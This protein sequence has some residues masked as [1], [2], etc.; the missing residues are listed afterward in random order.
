MFSIHLMIYESSTGATVCPFIQPTFSDVHA[1]VELGKKFRVLGRRS[2]RLR[3]GVMVSEDRRRSGGRRR[4]RTG[5]S[6]GAGK[7][8]R[9]DGALDRT[10]KMSDRDHTVLLWIPHL[11]SRGS[12]AQEMSSRCSLVILSC[13]HGDEEKTLLPSAKR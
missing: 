1:L 13:T 7:E 6:T 4:R 12:T 2:V 9:S 5:G 8:R 3:L 10:R 11:S